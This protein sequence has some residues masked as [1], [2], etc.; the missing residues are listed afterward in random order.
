MRAPCPAAW[1]ELDL[2]RDSGLE[3]PVPARAPAAAAERFACCAREE[4]AGGSPWSTWP[5]GIGGAL[6]V[7]GWTGSRGRM[8]RDDVKAVLVLIGGTH[9]RIRGSEAWLRW[10]AMRAWRAGPGRPGQARGVFLLPAPAGWERRDA[11][12][13]RPVFGGSA[14]G[15]PSTSP[16]TGGARLRPW[17]RAP[18]LRGLRQGGLSRGGGRPYAWCSW[19]RRDGHPECSKLFYRSSTR[20]AWRTGGRRGFRTRS[21][22]SPPSWGA[23]PSPRLPRAAART[24]GPGR[25]EAAEWPRTSSPVLGRWTLGALLSLEG[26][27]G[28]HREL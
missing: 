5:C 18:G 6:V 20:G 15:S 28:R 4:G 7:S 13:V 23:R 16:S 8:L 22:S 9:R 19:T 14:S 26:G 11:S 3:R 24:G 10:P 17:G 27:P 25:A 12:P 1:R 21:S 2:V